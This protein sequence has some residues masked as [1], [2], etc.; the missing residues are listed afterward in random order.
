MF[1]ELRFMQM[2]LEVGRCDFHIA[3][4]PQIASAKE[5]PR[6]VKSWNKKWNV[7]DY[8]RLTNHSDDSLE[9]LSIGILDHNLSA[10]FAGLD[11]NTS[12]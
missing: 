1:L 4:Q 5:L 10:A 3:T 7:E 11:I 2:V 12:I 9:I 8:R 6:S